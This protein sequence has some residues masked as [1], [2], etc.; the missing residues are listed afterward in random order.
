MSTQ[1]NTQLAAS[2]RGPAVIMLAAVLWGTVGIVTRLIQSVAPEVG[3]VA[4]SFFRVAFA[5]P[6][7]VAWAWHAVGPA[8]WRVTRRDFGLMLT[9]GVMMAWYQFS[10][11]AALQWLEVS[12]A[13]IITICSA[14]VLVAVLA[15]LFLNEAFTGRLAI[16]LVAVIAG[17]VLLS[18]LTPETIAQQAAKVTGVLF[19][20]G[21]G[22]GYAVLTLCSRALAGRYHPLQPIAIGFTVGAGLLLPFALGTAMTFSLA[23]LVWGGLLYLG[24]IPT[25]LAYWMFLYGIRHTSATVASIF[26]LIEPLTSTVLA[27]WLFGERLAP[28]GWLGAV[29]LLG[30]MALLVWRR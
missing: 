20:L 29:L 9:I 21:S 1:V 2:P 14:P 28:T 22:G 4:I 10:Y 15:A 23:W 30:A 16:A 6:V 8:W 25:A 11:F 27:A 5:A 13:I 18:G 19:A 24:L 26:T 7:L 12:V 17:T 3:A